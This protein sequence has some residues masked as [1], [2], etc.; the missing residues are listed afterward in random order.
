[1]IIFTGAGLKESVSGAFLTSQPPIQHVSRCTHQFASPALK[2]INGLSYF[3]SW[4]L[5]D[6]VQKLL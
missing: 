6:G 5:V 4:H 3:I 2:E 1:M